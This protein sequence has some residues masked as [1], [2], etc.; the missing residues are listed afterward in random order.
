MNTHVI[1][2][3]QYQSQLIIGILDTGGQ[4]KQRLF[5]AS[6]ETH[7]TKLSN[8]LSQVQVCGVV[9]CCKTSGSPLAAGHKTGH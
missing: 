5:V 8:D 7:P 9:S 3:Y 2:E 4:V 6:I 1:N